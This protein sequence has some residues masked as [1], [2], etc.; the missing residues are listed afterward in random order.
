MYNDRYHLEMYRDTDTEWDIPIFPP[1]PV[2]HSQKY[3]L[4]VLITYN[5]DWVVNDFD[6][7][8]WIEHGSA[9][10]AKRAEFAHIGVGDFGLYTANPYSSLSLSRR[11]YK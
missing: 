11:K 1:L 2:R 9:R 8:V 4:Y 10:W 5:D 7:G 3:V 6:T